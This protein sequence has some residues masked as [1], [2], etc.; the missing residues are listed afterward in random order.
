[1]KNGAISTVFEQVYFI[2]FAAVNIVILTTFGVR[3]YLKSET[4]EEPILISICLKKKISFR[5]QKKS[6]MNNGGSLLLGFCIAC[7]NFRFNQKS[8]I[9]NYPKIWK[10]STECSNFFSNSLV[11]IGATNIVLFLSIFAPSSRNFTR[12]CTDFHA[13]NNFGLYHCVLLLLTNFHNIKTQNQNQC[14]FY[15]RYRKQSDKMWNFLRK[16]TRYCSKKRF[17]RCRFKTN[18]NFKCHYQGGRSYA[19]CRIMILYYYRILYFNEACLGWSSL[20]WH[21]LIFTFQTANKHV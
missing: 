21:I 19:K 10:I 6:F 5:I 15:R 3:K 16:T 14:S 9:E 18:F 7:Q 13:H 11:D 1:V 12:N 8:E 20:E 4:D 17:Y 2:I